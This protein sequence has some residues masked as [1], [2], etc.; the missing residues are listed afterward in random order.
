MILEHSLTLHFSAL[1]WVKEFNLSILHP[2]YYAQEN[3]CYPQS[4]AFKTLSLAQICF[5]I[6]LLCKFKCIEPHR[7]WWVQKTL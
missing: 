3:N 5:A 4:L 2:H 6:K 1:M 7:R